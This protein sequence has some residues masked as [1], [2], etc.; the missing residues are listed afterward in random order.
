MKD[1]AAQRWCEAAASL[2]GRRQY[3]RVNEKDFHNLGPRRFKDLFG[4]FGG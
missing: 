3:L 2:T 4:L 1:E